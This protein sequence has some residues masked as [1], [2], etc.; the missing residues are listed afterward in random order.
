VRREQRGGKPGAADIPATERPDRL[1]QGHAADDSPATQ[2]TTDDAVHGQGIRA[3]GSAAEQA[4]GSAATRATGSGRGQGASANGSAAE[5][6]NSA[7][8]GGGHR[9]AVDGSTAEQ[10][11][12]GGRGGSA[13]VGG[14][15][16]GRA[17][18]GGHD[19]GHG[20][21][22]AGDGSVA[23]QDARE[24]G[25]GGLG[26]N[27]SGVSESGVSEQGAAGRRAAGA[28]E[29]A[30]LGVLWGAAG[31]LSPG[32]VRESLARTDSEGAA[33]SYSTV[34]T[35]LTRLHEKGSLTRERD[36]RAYRYAPVA[37]EAGLAARRL[38]QLLDRSAN[39]A[40][41]LSRFVADL[42]ERDEELLRSLL[43]GA[44]G[45]SAV[46]EAEGGLEGNGRG[47]R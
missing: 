30:V 35:I 1:V 33:L 10:A 27:E 42:S 5:H 25:V 9:T 8:S 3:R 29:S 18:N 14:A 19:H 43:A 4:G 36:G 11:D 23:G 38:S 7:V 44:D 17:D 2:M 28:L 45:A 12:G 31:A 46:D 34:V 39:R 24:S 6:A 37:D 26:V 15:V 41:V 16:V 21:G 13:A 22:A 20:H 47:R 40:A 32:E